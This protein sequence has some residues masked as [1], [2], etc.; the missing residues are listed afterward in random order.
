MKIPAGNDTVNLQLP[1]L[2]ELESREDVLLLVQTI[3]Q[4]NWKKG[5]ATV[6]KNF[7]I[8]VYTDTGK[9]KAWV[10][11][12]VVCCVV[13]CVL[14]PSLAVAVKYARRKR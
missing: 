12:V 9:N 6:S 3:S 1:V 10:A 11:G 5:K 2:K 4:Y 8:S 14:I 7:T 13:I